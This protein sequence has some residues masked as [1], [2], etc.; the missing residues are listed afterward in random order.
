[1][2]L[3]I[4]VSQEASGPR[5]GPTFNNRWWNDRRS[6]NLRTISRGEK[7]S[8]KGANHIQSCYCSPPSGTIECVCLLSAGSMTY[9]H[10]TSGY[11]HSPPPGTAESHM[12][13]FS[14]LLSIQALLEAD[15][16]SISFHSFLIAFPASLPRHS[17]PRPGRDRPALLRPTASWPRR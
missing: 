2:L 6:W 17:S 13:N 9:G 7:T 10:S 5:R 15:C 4:Q 14:Y 11:S 12:R 3:Y 1:M 8:P 16:K